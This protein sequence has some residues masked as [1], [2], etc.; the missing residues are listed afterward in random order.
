[1]KP[2]FDFIPPKPAQLFD[3]Q[4][5]IQPILTVDGQILPDL[6]RRNELLPLD[7]ICLEVIW[8]DQVLATISI[9]ESQ[10]KILQVLD[11]KENY[12]HEILVRLKGKEQGHTNLLNGQ[13]VTVCAEVTL[14]VEGIPVTDMIT[15]G[16]QLL[17]GENNRT[18]A[19]SVTTPIYRWLLDHYDRVYKKKS[20]ESTK[21]H[22]PFFW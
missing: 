12:V 5:D 8:D 22:S 16:G 3:L 13:E 19:L 14:F 6:T 10:S 9:Q 2:T 21:N 18:V 17:L 7:T 20:V 1:M 4:I 15:G 11:D